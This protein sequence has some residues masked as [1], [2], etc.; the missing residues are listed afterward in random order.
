MRS[1]KT[2]TQTMS[3]HYDVSGT[4]GTCM[5]ANGVTVIGAKS[6]VQ[7]VLTRFGATGNQTVEWTYKPWKEQ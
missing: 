3:Q 4:G 1:E 7:I 5:V 2:T 6:A